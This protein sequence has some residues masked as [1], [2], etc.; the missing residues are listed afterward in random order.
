MIFYLGNKVN[1]IVDEKIRKNGNT[2]KS[3]KYGYN[4]EYDVVIISK[5]GTL[6]TIYNINGLNIG[7]PEPPSD[8]KDICN[9]NK[10]PKS[11][12]WVRTELPKGLNKKTQYN[13]EFEEY[14]T[15]EIRRRKEGYWI[16]IKNELVYMPGTSY[17]FYQWNK[18]DE[19]YPNFRII[20]NELL[21][22]WEACK[23]D[24]R[25]YGICYVKNRR[26]GWSS[27]CN[28]EL[29]ESGTSN[30][31]KE[32]GIISKTGEDGRKMFSKLVRTFKKLPSFFMPV[33]DGTTTPKK[34]LLLSEPSRKKKSVE[35]EKTLDEGL[36][37]LIRYHSTVLNAMDG[38]KIFRSAIDECLGKGTKILMDDM[39]F[40]NIEEINVN[41]KVIV[42]GGKI[43][44][45]AKTFKGIDE[46]Y[47]VSQPYS[48]DY[49]VNSKHR[50]YL[51][52]RCKVANIKD[53]GI[54]KITP[55]EY[56]D[57]GKYK[58][59]TTF[60]VRS[61]GLE[62]KS[63][64]VDIEPYMFGVW[65]GDGCKETAMIAVNV[66]DTEI[67]DSIKDFCNTNNFSYKISKTSSPNCL[68]F[69]I[70]RPT[71]SRIRENKFIRTLKK[72]N[73]YR[74]KHIPIQYLNNSKENRL[75]LLAGLLD[76]DG[77]LLNRNNSY[78]YEISSSIKILADQI[79]VLAQSL[80][81]KT[82]I[83]KRLIKNKYTS[84]SIS[85]SGNINIIPCRV[86]RKK[87]P[88]S[89]K[90][91]YSKNINKI[92]IK[93]IG[94]KTYYGVQLE[95]YNDNDRRL[96]LEDFTLT[97]NCGK[98]PKETPFDQ[99]WRIV[100]T[101]H[102]QGSRIV[103][104]AMVGSTVNSMKKGGKEFK[105]I[106][107]QS[108][109]LER[110]K[111]G[112]TASG[113]YHL[114]ISAHFGLEGYYDTFG[115]SI[116]DIPKKPIKNDLGEWVSIGAKKHLENELEALKDD[117]EAYNEQLRQF[118][119][120]VKDAFRDESD[121]C[122]F[123]LN[124]LLEQ[125][126]HNEEEHGHND[127]G[128][129]EIERGNFSWKDGIQDTEVIWRPNPEGRF[130]IK[131]G[132][133]PPLEYRNLKEMKYER[134]VRAWSPLGTS[135]GCFGVDPYNRSKSADGRGS[136]GAIHLVT[137]Y[138]TST[139]PNDTFILEY[140]DRPK[141]VTLFFEDVIMAMVYFSIPM[142]GELSNEA[143]LKYVKDRGYRHYS[144]NNPFKSFREL[145]PTERELGGAP[146]QNA[147]IGEQQ[148]YA[149]ESYIEDYVGVS[150][151][152]RKRPIGEM[153]NM[154][155]NRT[156]SQWK[157]VDTENRTKFD[158]YISSS[159]ALLGNQRRVVIKKEV[160]KGFNPFTKFNNSGLI[161]KT[162]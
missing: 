91:N 157:E 109:P 10:T 63:K 7:M 43:V 96:I 147:K 56:L 25:C 150:L 125:I 105:N 127:Y 122:D 46:M 99:Y 79:V 69:N 113:L 70:K 28:N 78:K 82:S 55:T 9:W 156:L 123:N 134:G 121:D 50:L 76:T 16:Y 148:F 2:L 27:I 49:T 37:T 47:L 40:K 8:R 35:D 77:S 119:P 116:V 143:F 90:R 58:Q 102:R 34:E 29:V 52:Q 104:K 3:W 133:H 118:P 38:D 114:F 92:D 36:D 53:D 60:G 106:Y 65:L 112:Q 162:A 6:G 87:V 59:R 117:V 142:L 107:Y 159:L 26:F 139:L 155:F 83:R 54:K 19:G 20:Q 64:E 41:D 145:N 98:F 11:Q 111:N 135:L 42:E 95:A 103:G 15:E 124:K 132:C 81:F 5:D 131:K 158:A 160:S 61:N 45:V 62:L 89:Y 151:D 4:E 154:V 51:E 94:K 33:W 57:L 73:I 149:V 161:S 85:I 86:K 101:S 12:K 108:N 115:F 32:L 138:N 71:N 136:K 130:W 144:L 128:S 30:E 22:Y 152:E 23:A 84:W 75:K 88:L 44:R 93:P 67:L 14:I 140:L 137:K 129:D 72:Y 74:N 97:M 48:K 21:I 66:K 120:T 39:T 13:K 1:D 146:P 126:D 17:Y 110:N 24:K 100:K 80:G 153:G 68:K 141:K 18:L 31:N